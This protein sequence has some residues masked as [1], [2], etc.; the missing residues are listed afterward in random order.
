LNYNIE[1]S[2]F[3]DN[4]NFYKKTAET[5]IGFCE[6]NNIKYHI[7]QGTPYSEEKTKKIFK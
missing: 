4:E 7:K 1:A 3:P 6:T 2:K 5:L